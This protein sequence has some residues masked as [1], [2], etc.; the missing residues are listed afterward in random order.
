[1]AFE[2]RELGGGAGRDVGY[3]G[4]FIRGRGKRKFE[5]CSLVLFN[6]SEYPSMEDFTRDRNTIQA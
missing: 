4:I 6:T 3:E 5:I 2:Q 1:M